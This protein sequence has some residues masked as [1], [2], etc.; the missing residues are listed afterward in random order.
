MKILMKC[1]HGSRLYGLHNENSDI[2]YK[3]VY[4]PTLRECILGTY[5]PVIEISSAG[6]NSAGD[7][8][9]TYYSLQYFINMALAGSP[10]A[11]EMLHASADTGTLLETSEIWYEIAKRRAWFYTDKISNLMEFAQNQAKRYGSRIAN[12]SEL[13]ELQKQC[14]FFVERRRKCRIFEIENVLPVTDLFRF[15][16]TVNNGKE[17][18]FYNIMDKSYETKIFV[19]DMLSSLNG[20]IKRYGARVKSGNETNTDWK[21]V[22]HAARS[23]CQMIEILKYGDFNYP[24]PQTD[25]LMA[26][27]LGQ[28]GPEEV[29][30]IMDDLT[31]QVKTLM[32]NNT[33]NAEPDRKYWENFI[34][35][36]YGAI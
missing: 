32:E 17:C 22:S 34:V 14:E 19:S 20:I 7:E 27:K 36:A 35:N 16:T 9:H 1:Y 2:D 18:K 11:I 23:M 31:K 4:L 29:A 12:Y 21:S 3:Y 5:K 28:F 24:L 15:S 10:T 6:Q 33:L 26:I 8:D 13:V 25:M 30:D